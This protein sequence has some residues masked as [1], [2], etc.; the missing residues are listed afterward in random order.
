MTFLKCNEVL[1]V[2]AILL[3]ASACNI[4]PDFSQASVPD[5]TLSIS[6]GALC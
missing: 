5:I 6:R 2:S 1:A 3:T 4:G